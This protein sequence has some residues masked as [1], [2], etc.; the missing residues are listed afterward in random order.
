VLHSCRYPLVG[1]E[2]LPAAELI[3]LDVERKT[4]VR[5]DYEPLPSVYM[6][7]I[8]TRRVWWNEAG[9]HLHFVHQE[10][11]YRT[12]HLVTADAALGDTQALH[13]ESSRTAIDVTPTPMGVFESP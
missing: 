2:R 11:G 7:P 3:V 6:S 1:D 8:E 5:I 12:L 10:R 4:A 13:T 9:T